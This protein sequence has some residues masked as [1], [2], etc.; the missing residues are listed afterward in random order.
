MDRRVARHPQVRGVCA[1]WHRFW[2]DGLDHLREEVCGGTKRGYGR[3]SQ[4][5]LGRVQPVT[6]DWGRKG[7]GI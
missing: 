2:L 6:R 4:A 5:A 7:L 1:Q 3:G